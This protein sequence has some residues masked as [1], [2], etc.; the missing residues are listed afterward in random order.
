LTDFRKPSPHRF[1]R[2]ANFRDLAG[3]T[4][5]DGRRVAPGRLLRSGHLGRATDADLVILSGFG[6]R[7]VY[8]FRTQS[9]ITSDGADRLPEGTESMCLP[10]PDPASGRGIRELIDE[11]GPDELEIHFGDGKAEAMMM[12]SAAGLVRE[13]REPYGVFLRALAEESGVPA[14]FHC[15]AGKDR[16]GWAASVVLLTLG[17]PEDQVIEQYL[18]SNRAAAEIVDGQRTHG[19]EIWADVLRPLLEVREEYIQS[20]FDTVRREWGDFDGYLERGLGITET[21]R[22]AIRRNLLD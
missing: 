2:V 8:D 22:D 9:D 3:H 15:S 13:R 21:E 6:L 12:E 18:L 16:A 19:R 1:E 11:S 17:V 7:R 20:S 14:L 4:T 5:R 10:M